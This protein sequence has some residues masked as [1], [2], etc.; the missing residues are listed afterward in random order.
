MDERKE[1]REF[2]SLMREGIGKTASELTRFPKRF[3]SFIIHNPL[4][5]ALLASYAAITYL[6]ID[7]LKEPVWSPLTRGVAATV[8]VGIGISPLV[9]G[10][11]L[12]SHR[13]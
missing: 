5:S 2:V 9:L 10:V 12:G 4:E 13:Q 6:G 3:V 7:G 1:G 8:A 11:A